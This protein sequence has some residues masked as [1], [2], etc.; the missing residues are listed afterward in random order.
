MYTDIVGYTALTQSNEAQ[1]I[2]VLERHNRLLRPFFPKYHG[3]EVKALGDGFL[4]EFENALDAVRCA[5]EIQSYLHDFNLSSSDE[6]KIKL[7][8]GI[9][10][11]DVIRKGGDVFGDAVNI[12]SRIQPIAAAEGVCVSEQ[13][14]YQVQN[15]LGMSMV[16]LGEKALKNVTTP[17]V[18]YAV[19][20]PWEQ[21]PAKEGTALPRD[22]IAI[23]PFR[24]MSPDP[25][26]EY[27]A[28]GMTEEIISTVSGISGL[29]V[30]SRT[31]VMGYKGTTKKVREI[32]KE[33]EVGS[34]LEGSFRK[35]GN[36]IRV[37][38]QLIDV[39]GDEHL[40]SQSYDRELDDVFTVQSDIAKQVAEALRVNMASAEMGRVERKPTESTAAYA[41]YLKGRYHFNKRGLEDVKRAIEYF[42]LAIHEDPTFALGYSGLSDCSGV[43]AA[44]WNEEV[45]ANGE[46]A[47]EYAAKALELDPELAEAHA[48]RGRTL[49]GWH[50]WSESEKEY[51]KAIELKPSYAST[52]HWYFLLLEAQMRKEEARYHI[53]RAAEL[54]PLSPIICSEHGDYYSRLERNYDVALEL[55]KRA[56]EL[57]P[58]LAV[59]HGFCGFLYC[60]L[61]RFED[62]Q[63]EADAAVELLRSSYPLVKEGFEAFMADFL[64]DKETVRKLL[65]ELKLH[66][67]EAGIGAVDIAQLHFDLGEIDQGFEWLEKAY[68]TK[69]WALT[70][71][72]SFDYLDLLRDDPR[73]LELLKRL[74][75]DEPASLQEDSK[76]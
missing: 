52:H 64:G 54:D 1:A 44:N 30:I 71:L 55:V 6:W 65:P 69:E 34:V 43:L 56:I 16:S 28:E 59:T 58:K 27:F 45:E 62:A 60:K 36:R 25:G 46:K 66:Q 4:I 50:D 33:L 10:L 51:R 32:G 12:A 75:L 17:V 41:L 42:Q 23:L 22:R 18:V 76:P 11:G 40:W 31:S 5:T 15:K 13:V 14:C 26:D 63:R 3:R 29:K 21:Q 7:R 35:A 8:I 61:K 2:E 9:H 47:L 67:K 70:F 57:D 68:Q 20:M 53:R 19:V 39:A 38:T 49:M 72:K 37:T 73:Y 74:G 24:N 48:S